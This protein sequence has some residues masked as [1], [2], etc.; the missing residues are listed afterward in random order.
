MR[1]WP[2]PT[3]AVVL[4]L[5]GCSAARA[6]QHPA[7]RQ[8]ITAYENLNFAAAIANARFALEQRPSR[9]DR[10]IAYE[11]LGFAYGALDSAAQALDA[12]KELIFLDPNRE[13]DPQRVSPRITSLYASALGQ[14]LIVR[15]LAVDSTSFVAG[16]GSVPI[17]FQVSRAARAVTRIVGPEMDAVIDSQL[18]TALTPIEVRWRT[19]RAGR[20]VP[21]GRYQIIVAG[22]E[23]GN[24]Y[25]ATTAVRVQHTP[26]DTL[27]HRTNLEGYREQP[28]FEQPPRDWRPLGIAVLYAGLSSAATLALEDTDLGGGVKPAVFGVSLGALLTGVAMSLKKPDPRPIPAAIEFNRLLRAQIGQ[29]NAEIA[30]ENEERRR[31]TT[32]IVVP[33]EDGS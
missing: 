16:E 3:L 2:A 7:L 9:D 18:V 10:I 33:V 19:V 20:P 14:V 24:E 8:A 30:R 5:A 29:I 32:M 22:I 1:A 12:F 23:G 26:V 4:V 27:P 25:A 28:E 11:V 21:P 6:Q 31:K 17:R 15:R 13:P